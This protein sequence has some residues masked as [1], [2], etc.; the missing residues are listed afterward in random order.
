MHF[1]ETRNDFKTTEITLYLLCST[2]HQG[3]VDKFLFATPLG[4]HFQPH[5]ILGFN[6]EQQ[7]VSEARHWKYIAKENPTV[8]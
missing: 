1:K 3:I 6:L 5:K 7:F 2:V 4:L 8:V